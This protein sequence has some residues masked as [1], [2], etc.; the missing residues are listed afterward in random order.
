MIAEIAAP[1]ATDFGTYI[2]Q[3]VAITPAAADYT[4]AADLG[5][6]RNAADFAFS[7]E[8][9]ALLVR[10]GFF[11]TPKRSGANTGYKEMYD[12]YNEA[13]ET[14][15]PIFVTIDALLHTFH[16]VFDH[17]LMEIEEEYFYGDLDRLL[18]GLFDIVMYEQYPRVTDDSTRAA[19]LRT[20]DYLIVAK[21]LLDSTFDPRINGGNYLRELSLIDRHETFEPSPIFSYEEDY[22]QYIVRGHYTRSDSLRRYFRAMMWLGR[23]TFAADPR[24]QYEQLN[25]SATLSALLLLQA[26]ERLEIAGEPA[27]AVWDRIYAPTVFFVGKSD[28]I[29]P[30]AYRRLIRQIYG[31]EFAGLDVN[32]IGAAPLFDPFL[33]AARELPGPQIQY[34]GQPQG[35]RF[36]GQ[37]FIPDSYILDQLVYDHVPGRFMPKGLD[38]MA[39]LG[40]EQACRHLESLGEMANPA[41]KQRLEEL[42]AE[43]RGYPAETWAQ[44]LYWNWLYSLMPLLWAKGEGYPPFM[45]SAAWVDKELYAALGSWAELRHD[46]ILYAKQ[47]GTE[48]G[49]PAKNRLHQGYVEPNPHFYGR[50]AALAQFLITGLEQRGLLEVRFARHLGDFAAL[51]LQLKGIAEKELLDRSLSYEEYETILNFGLALEK[52]A[53]FSEYPEV[54]GPSP[55]SEEA[56]PVIADVHSDLNAMTCLEEGVGY[57]FT[58]Y[59]VC[60]VE[61]ELVVTRGAGFSYYEFEHPMT[62]RLTDEAWRAMLHKGAEPASPAWTGS[63]LAGMWT[64]SNPGFYYLTKAEVNGLILRVGADTLAAGAL[65]QVEIGTA[66]D[67]FAAAPAV[68]LID[69]AGSATA[70]SGVSAAGG[71]YRAEIPTDGL[72]PGRWYIE[73]KGVVK[74][75]EEV[76]PLRSRTSFVVSGA[77]GVACPA[78]QTSPVEAGLL[79]NYPNPFNATTV[80]RYRLASAAEVR[81]TICDLS[82]RELTVLHRGR[83]TAGEHAVSWSG[84]DGSGRSVPSGLYFAL[85]QAGSQR[86]ICKMVVMR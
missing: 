60:R 37:R 2:P 10:Q 48:R 35:F 67:P 40:S 34:P 23:M 64:N 81:L 14:G 39:V 51:A 63:F 52:L 7:A 21:T 41:Y 28:D 77:T 24:P 74:H 9:S 83:A 16:L 11:V 82:G 1:V 32:R 15:I 20:M 46:T 58:L 69:A 3:P 47:S 72:A 25:R 73:V 62:D 5:N 78:V 13:R 6:V 71:G 86:Q 66:G 57:P 80:I 4:V 19:L 79:R 50:M 59:V 33:A 43:F 53:E 26:M 36:M 31:G 84:L 22:T 27:A 75:W 30:L 12:L 29:T 18:T 68:Y 8:E 61:G 49:L 17:M 42:R 65:Q 56:M 70:V 38:V 54:S 44:N 55:F 85:L 45:R 76:I